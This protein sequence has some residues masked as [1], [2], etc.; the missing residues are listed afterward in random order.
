MKK[1]AV[2]TFSNGLVY[3]LNPITTPNNVL[4]DCVNGTFVT[5]NGDELALQ[6]DAGNT[7]IITKGVTTETVVSKTIKY[8]RLY[9]QNSILDSRGIAPDG[10]H[11]PTHAEWTTLLA[12]CDNNSGKLMES[13]SS[14]WQSSSSYATNQFGFSVIP[15]GIWSDDSNTF[16]SLGTYFYGWCSGGESLILFSSN[17]WSFYNNV[18]YIFHYWPAVRL[19]KDN[20]I[21]EGSIV[22]D[23]DSYDTVTIGSQ[24]WLAENLATKHYKNGDLINEI[25]V[26]S[27]NHN[28]NN[29]YNFTSSTITVPEQY[30]SLTEGFYPIGVKEFGGVLYIVSG[31]TPASTEWTTSGNYSIG[32]FVHD[33][34]GV[35]YKS[36]IN[37]NNDTLPTYTNTSWERMESWNTFANT[38]GQIEFGSYPSPQILTETSIGNGIEFI[39]NDP[40]KFS[41]FT[42][43]VLN[44]YVFKA[45]EYA[46]FEGT[47]LN[48]SNVTRYRYDNNIR[49]SASLRIY[50][51]KLYLQLTNGFIDLTTDVW[52][53]Y[54]R[55][56]GGTLNDQFWF[57]D[58][59]FKYYCKN[60]FKGKLVMSVELED[61]PVFKL[62]YYNLDQIDGQGYQ[63]T[64]NIS[65]DNQITWNITHLR[66][67]YSLDEWAT[68]TWSDIILG[69]PT[70]DYVITIPFSNEGKT[71]EFSITPV[72]NNPG[73][74]DDV[75]DELPTTYL[76]KYTLSGSELLTNVFNYDSNDYEEYDYY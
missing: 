72:F 65:V 55:F 40:T 1:E 3:D 54:A 56:K 15:S 20:S 5:F 58:L 59:D 29:V 21:N 27:Y 7:K 18:D 44:N 23:G 6:N 35:Y 71:L 52:N 11:I 38:Y 17:T 69:D 39:F 32:T 4:T 75:T 9:S 51:V 48:L 13:G 66:I 22:I 28:E 33:G 45:G 31:K 62:N 41:L 42:S 57:N 10:W 14:H 36:L 53:E 67:N 76:N 8:G 37:S 25:D 64:F 70:D 46:T 60:N 43:N 74:T 26:I 68:R 63:A 19:I 47:N 12:Y 24:V 30:V 61:L 73:T 49:I 2:N 16:G 50:N 34:S